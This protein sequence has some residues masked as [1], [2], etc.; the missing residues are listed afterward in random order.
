MSLGA[1]IDALDCEC[2]W[3]PAVNSPGSFAAFCNTVGRAGG[4]DGVTDGA[5]VG[6]ACGGLSSRAAGPVRWGSV[7]RLWLGFPLEHLC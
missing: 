2:C 1:Q 6:Q 3:R 4:G 7:E 5:P